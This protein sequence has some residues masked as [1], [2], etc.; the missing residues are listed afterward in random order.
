MTSKQRK[1]LLSIS[2]AALLLTA[3]AVYLCSRGFQSEWI[4]EE[5]YESVIPGMSRSEVEAI[6][7]PPRGRWGFGRTQSARSLKPSLLS[8]ETRYSWNDC[9]THIDVTFDVSGQVRDKSIGYRATNLGSAGEFLWRVAQIWRCGDD[10]IEH[11]AKAG[12]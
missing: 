5:M 12:E 1:L 7:G 3:I 8:G 11:A 2:V 9:H 4:T 6:L 10:G